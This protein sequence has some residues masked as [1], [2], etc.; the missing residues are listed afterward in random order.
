MSVFG[1]IIVAYEDFVFQKLVNITRI[2]LN[3][4]VMIAMLM[5]GYRA[6]GMTVITTLFNVV[7]LLVNC[8]Y[9][10]HKIHIRIYF[11]HFKWGFLKEVSIYSFWIFLNAIMDRIYWSSG[12]FILGMYKGAVAVAVYAVAIQLQGI[13]M[14]F[15]T[16]ISGVFLPK[17][18]AMVAKENNEKAISDLFIRMGRI[19]YAIMAFILTG[20]ILFGKVFIYFWAASD[21]VPAK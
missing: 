21:Y 19:Q 16:A 2:I 20:F 15:S 9:C 6:I 11:G 14:S 1:S 4:L 13:Y 12:Q 5:L 3:P 17:V 10:F 8:W 18:T 7:T